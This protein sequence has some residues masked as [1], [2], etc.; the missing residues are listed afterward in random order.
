MDREMIDKAL[1]D[2]SPREPI[3]AVAD[4][5]RDLMKLTRGNVSADLGVAFVQSLKCLKRCKMSQ[6]KADELAKS[7]AHLP[8]FLRKRGNHAVATIAKHTLQNL[9][10]RRDKIVDLPPNMPEEAPK[11][12]LQAM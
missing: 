4:L 2:E 8:D 12:A 7:L 10:R 1:T 11:Q 5:I 3:D 6:E 9:K